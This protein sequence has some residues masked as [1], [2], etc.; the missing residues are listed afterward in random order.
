MT[1]ALTIE[2]LGGAFPG[3]VEVG[4]AA[5]IKS[6]GNATFSGIVTA[7]SFVGDGTGLTGVASTDNI[8]TGTPAIFLSNVNIS[9]ASTVGNDATF[10]GNVS[11]GGSLTV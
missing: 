3:G 1:V 8:Q 9:G 6:N 10:N 2:G 11:I 5:T 4:T 7:S